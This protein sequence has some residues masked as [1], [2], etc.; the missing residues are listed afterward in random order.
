M[1]ASEPRSPRPR[2]AAWI[3]LILLT[4]LLHAALMATAFAPF[5]LWPCAL[6]AVAPLAWIA[7]RLADQ[8]PAVGGWRRLAA[9]LRLIVLV[10]LGVLPFNLYEQQW[11]ANVSALG[12]PPMAFALSL[13]PGLFVVLL[14]AACRRFPRLP[15]SLAV[16]ILWTGVEV[17]RG[18][19]AFSGYPW[20]LL[21]H[22]LI[23][24]PI[25]AAPA[26]VIGTYGVSFL[27]A[28]PAGL[29]A[30][31][32]WTRPRRRIVPALVGAAAA[33]LIALAVVLQPAPPAGPAFRIAVVQTNVPQDNKVDWTL[34]QK[35]ADFAR[36]LELTRQAAAAD[37]PPDVIV[38]PETM[39]PGKFLDP[40]AVALEK[41]IQFYFIP[42]GRPTYDL[43]HDP[44]LALQSELEIPFL[45]GAIGVDNFHIPDGDRL[46]KADHIYN[47][48]FLLRRGR[49]EEPRYDKIVL[50]PFG[51]VMPYIS[52]WSWL[53]QQLLA[54]G[55]QGMT[56]D[57]SAGTR[58]HLFRLPSR[59]ADRAEVAIA[60][61]ICFE[62]TKPNLCRRLLATY[63]HMPRVIVNL[64]NDGW[65]GAFV[66]G[67]WHHLQV[68]RWRAVELGVPVVRA[69]NTG[70]SAWIDPRGRIIKTGVE[71][72]GTAIVDGLLIADVTPTTGETI[73]ARAGDVLGWSALAATVLLGTLAF[74]RRGPV[75]PPLPA[76]ADRPS[77]EE[78]R[79]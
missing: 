42:D 44:L 30:D 24:W 34:D 9:A 55:A 70:V 39:F 31:L 45:I 4:G 41:R 61:P 75:E 74:L 6:V 20:F 17:F 2:R 7:V 32:L 23:D 26:S 49:V 52:A 3:L 25:L 37:P 27:A 43:F 1:P 54:L 71:S 19:V 65:F 69:A 13:F 78:V 16:P 5:G 64:T 10:A 57:L 36:F 40:H 76:P 14:R 47:S 51:E 8:P 59:L 73:Y 68:A 12:Y 63:A 38:W 72:G 29:A 50:T 56:F 21:A 53:E 46:P 77:K 28:I 60:T 66:P 22:P 62:A 11:V 35:I 67:R 48:V 79:T 33:A 58:P 18:E 15:L